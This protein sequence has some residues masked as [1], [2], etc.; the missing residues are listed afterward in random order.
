MKECYSAQ[1]QF[2]RT[3][4]HRLNI[5][6][7]SMQ[8]RRYSKIKKYLWRSA[9]CQC[10]CRHRCASLLAGCPTSAPAQHSP[11]PHVTLHLT[12]NSTEGLALSCLHH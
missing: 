3:E 9:G 1:E 5:W 2:Q 11:H 7:A 4:A 10:P 12:Q 8:D 6:Q